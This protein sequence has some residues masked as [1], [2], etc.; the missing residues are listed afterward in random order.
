[1]DWQEVY[2]K[3]RIAPEEAAR[4]VRSGDSVM[5]N[6]IPHPCVTL[7]RALEARAGELEN[8]RVFDTLPVTL[9]AWHNPMHAESFTPISCF[10]M[11]TDRMVADENRLDY[12]ERI[13]GVTV[14]QAERMK[15]LIDIMMINTFLTVINEALCATNYGN[16]FT[17]LV[18]V[19]QFT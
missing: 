11:P 7:R 15:D 12:E 16:R 18:L 8:V 5:V 3:K 4:K 19:N 10:L 2:K 9:W 17:D 14:K 13:S 1:M 6:G